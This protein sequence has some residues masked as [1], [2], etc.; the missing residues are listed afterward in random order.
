MFYVNLAQFRK[1]STSLIMSSSV[2]RSKIGVLSDKCRVSPN[3]VILQNVL[4]YSKD[5][6]FI[7]FDK[8]SYRSQNILRDDFNTFTAREAYWKV[9]QTSE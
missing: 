6:D 1:K 5:E 4:Y 9:A 2:I 3:M 8:I 7:L